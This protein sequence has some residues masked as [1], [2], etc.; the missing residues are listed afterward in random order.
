M[1]EGDPDEHEELH[2][3]IEAPSDAQMNQAADLVRDLL[4][5]PEAATKLREEQMRQVRLGVGCCSSLCITVVA[6]VSCYS[7]HLSVRSFLLVVTMVLAGVFC[8]LGLLSRFSDRDCFA[9]AC[10]WVL[11]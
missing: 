4:Y 7:S 5:N 9:V 10:P 2:V 11:R 1:Q 8:A 6:Y 3:F